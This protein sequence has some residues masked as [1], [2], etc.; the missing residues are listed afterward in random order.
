MIMSGLMKSLTFVVGLIIFTA[1]L[2]NHKRHK[3]VALFENAKLHIK[4][5]GASTKINYSGLLLFQV[6]AFA[7]DYSSNWSRN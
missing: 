1:S 6:G 2:F 3:A 5:T 7:E 4:K